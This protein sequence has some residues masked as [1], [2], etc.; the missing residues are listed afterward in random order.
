MVPNIQIES[1]A[2]PLL[3]VDE[4]EKVQRQRVATIGDKIVET[5]S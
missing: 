1:S 4:V 3:T 5:L 2:T